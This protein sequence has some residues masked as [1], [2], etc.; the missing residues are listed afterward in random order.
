MF[1]RVIHLMPFFLVLGQNQMTHIDS[2]KVPDMNHVGGFEMQLKTP[3]DFF[4]VTD[5]GEMLG[6]YRAMADPSHA[7]SKH[8]DARAATQAKTREELQTAFALAKEWIRPGPRQGE[9]NDAAVTQSSWA[10]IIASA[11]RHNKPG[12][13]TTFIGYE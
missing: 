9:L 8:P 11:N 5:H 2:R 3:L 13:F 6:H 10:E 12:E 1:T 4:S 7:L